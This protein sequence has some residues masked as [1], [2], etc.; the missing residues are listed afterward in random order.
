MVLETVAIE[1]FARRATSSIVTE[2]AGFSAAIAA[3]I[4]DRRRIIEKVVKICKR[5]QL[6]NNKDF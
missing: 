5:F 6:V 3:K 4:G 1:T 2:D